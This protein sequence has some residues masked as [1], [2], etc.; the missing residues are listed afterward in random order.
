MKWMIVI[1]AAGAV[2]AGGVWYFKRGHTDAPDYQ[3]PRS[4]REI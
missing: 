2:I 4:P 3:T 1:V